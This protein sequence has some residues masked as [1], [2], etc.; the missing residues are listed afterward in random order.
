MKDSFVTTNAD[1]KFIDLVR[2]WLVTLPHDLKVAFEAMDDENLARPC[3]EIAVG[4]IIYVV[5]P[6]DAI[7]DRNDKVVSFA[8]DAMLLRLALLEVVAKRDE[9]ADTFRERYPDVFEGLEDDLKLCSSVMGELWSWLESKAKALRTLEYKGKKI[10][11]YLD[12]DE[13]REQ[14]FEDGMVF[15]TDYP[16]DEKTIGDKLKKSSTVVDMLRR[17]KAEESRAG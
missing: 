16:V 13:A 6:H 10:A 5:T 17:R 15:R 14:L 3:R 1:T 9:D 11:V 12:N 7:S 8:D 4:A 2:N